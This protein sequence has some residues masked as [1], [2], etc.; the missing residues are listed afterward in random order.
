MLGTL[1]HGD[2]NVADEDGAFQP[3]FTVQLPDA[4]AHLFG[5]GPVRSQDFGR[6]AF[7]RDGGPVGF[8]FAPARLCRGLVHKNGEMPASLLLCASLGAQQSCKQE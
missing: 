4:V 1:D 3:F 6:Q 7:C 5:R 2:R 8:Q